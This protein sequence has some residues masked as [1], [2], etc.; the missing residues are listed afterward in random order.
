ME[1]K[2]EFKYFTIFE[3]QK[4][5][6][7]LRQQHKSGWKFLKVTGFGVYHFVKCQPE[8]VIYQ[9]D[10]NQEASSNKMFADCGWDYIL[11]YA[12]YSYFCKS[13]A[14]MNGEEE[15]FSDDSS[16]LAMMERVYKGRLLPLLVIFCAVL[17]PQFVMNL[18][19][20]RYVVAAI[21][22]AILSIYV[23]LFSYCAYQYNQQKK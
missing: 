22:G 17:L 14:A 11:D 2:K 21:M 12:G 9:L 5:E 23:A 10:Y 3:H 13:A 8:D 18:A 1:T 19:S 16:R 20:G 7:Y 4:E 6:I 15:I